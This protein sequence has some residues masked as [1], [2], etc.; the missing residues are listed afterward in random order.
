MKLLE[1]SWLSYRRLVIPNAAEPTQVQESRR[2]FY[3]GASSLLNGLLGLFSKEDREPTAG[4]MKV[5]D[6]VQAELKA[7]ERDV[8]AGRA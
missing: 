4:D 3:G 1:T 8:A 7:F 6:E 5:M 2:A